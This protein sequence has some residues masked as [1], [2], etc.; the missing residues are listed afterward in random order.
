MAS[1]V[2]CPFCGEEDFD[3]IGLKHHLEDHCEKYNSTLSIEE[4]RKLHYLLP[5]CYGLF[6]EEYTMDSDCP[7]C[8]IFNKCK[9]HTEEVNAQL[10]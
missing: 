8:G 2:V 4:E 9:Q 7:R 1:D 6:N 3:L 5:S 10:K